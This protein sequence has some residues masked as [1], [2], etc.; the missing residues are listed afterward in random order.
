[1]CGI[2]GIIAKGDQRAHI[3]RM[4]RLLHHRGPESAS[5]FHK[6]A[7]WLGHNRLRIIDL[8]TG[9]Q[10]IFNEDK[11][12]A[13]VFNG[14]IYNYRELKNKLIQK[15][16]QFRTESDTE[17]IVH[18]YEEDGVDCFQKLNGIFSIAIYDM[19]KEE[20][21]LA[22]D[23]FG[24][25]PLHYYQKG[26]ELIFAS[27]IKAIISHPNVPRETN[28]WAVHL[29]SNLR[30][31]QSEQTLFKDIFRL[32]PGHF[33]IWKK[34]QSKI[35]TFYK[36][37]V[38][39]K[40]IST[41]DAIEGIRFHL[42]QAIK[43]QLVSDVPMGVYLSGGL[44]SGSIVA[45]MSE[46]GVK[47]LKTFTLGF[48]EPTDEFTPAKIVAKQFSTQHHELALSLDPL[49]QME[50]V[51]WHAEESKINLL[52]GYHLSKFVGKHV[53]VVLGGLGGDEL[54]AGYDIH[55]LLKPFEWFNRLT[56]SQFEKYISAPFSSGLGSVQRKVSSL[57]W[58]EVRRGIQ[59]AMANG[60]PLKQLLMIR[61]VWD[62]E[63]SMNKQI[64]SQEFYRQRSGSV[65]Q[66]FEQ[67]LA[68]SNHPQSLETVLDIEFQS[69]MVNDYLLTEDR[70]SMSHS[71]EER[72]PFLDK[73][74]VEFA[75]SIPANLKIK[76]GRKKS[77]LRS[78]MSPYLPKEIIEKKKWG[79]TVNPYLQFQK[80]LKQTVE[81]VL[82][83]ELV[84]KQGIFNY[85]Y[86]LSILEYKPSPKLRWHYNF[87]WILAG[88]AIWEKMFIQTDAFM[89][90]DHSL[91][92]YY[93]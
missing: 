76:S 38:K 15:G 28:N 80:D 23:H 86:I 2:S 84:E 53:K 35:K 55:R 60:N 32:A 52:Q 56:P 34:G 29:M 27:E 25:K 30:Y 75:F 22:R 36:I 73:D 79:F 20:V 64:Y 44:D 43:R 82:T 26:Q 92:T 59:I 39:R 68:K 72:V 24:V 10:P 33:M 90:K 77:I 47:D 69:K 31:I 93:S 49:S 3:K 61:N 48:N 50:E 83:R 65:K 19:K 62:F 1:M 6:N 91:E 4:C 42:K 57:K 81:K 51:I 17:V 85:D 71:V 89:Q 45:M 13:I 16:H 12:I 7:T 8:H 18:Q 87:L 63:S 67:I 21:I 70:M 66:E 88:L 5:F 78:A 14:E 46:L 41:N 9:D 58:D 37:N 54:F 11:S 74:L 40:N